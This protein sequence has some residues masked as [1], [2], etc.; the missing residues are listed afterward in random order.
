MNK[1]NEKIMS[2]FNKAIKNIRYPFMMDDNAVLG[3]GNRKFDFK[4]INEAFMKIDEEYH[5]RSSERLDT[6]HYMGFVLGY[7]KALEDKGE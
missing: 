2:P 1:L 7:D 5:A 3:R 6:Y 4:K